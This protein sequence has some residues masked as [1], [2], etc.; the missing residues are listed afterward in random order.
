MAAAAKDVAGKILAIFFPIWLFV[1]SGFEH[2]VANMYYIPAG[3]LA[4]MNPAYVETAKE[5]YS[6]TDAQLASLNALDSL[7]GFFFVMLGNFIGGGLVIGGLCYLT[8]KK[9]Y[10]KEF[11]IQA[12]QLE[13]EIGFSKAAKELGVNIDTLY[14]WNKRTKDDR[15]DLEL[16]MQT[17]DAAM[18]L[19]EEVQNL[20]QQSSE[21]SKEIARLKEENEF[22]AEA[23]AFFAANRQKSAKN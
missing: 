20:R 8:Q 1:A 10:D 19:T 14:G 4:A 23:S 5:L 16:G 15:F 7:P 22:L 3:I 11:K 17:L 9:V 13:R 21:Q 18:S 12:V 2:V 6:L